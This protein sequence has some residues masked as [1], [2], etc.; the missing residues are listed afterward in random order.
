MAAEAYVRCLAVRREAADKKDAEALY[1]LGL[2]AKAHGLQADAMVLFQDVITLKP[3]HEF[4]RR[5]LGYQFHQGTW[6]T[7]SEVKQAM[8]LIEFEGDWMTP[9]AKEAVLTARTLRKEREALEETR[10]KVDADRASA[11]AE[12]EAQRASLDARALELER[13][14]AELERR[15]IEIAQAQVFAA[16]GHAGCGLGGVHVHCT[17]PGCA[18]TTVHVHCTRAGCALTTAHSH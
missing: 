9:G 1:E 14:L 5:A 13:K 2:W 7:P 10:K 12:Y 16:C 17:R 8:G 3:N 18:I 6:M 11:R 15:R 4:A